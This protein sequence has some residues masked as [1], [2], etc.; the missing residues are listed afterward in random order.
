MNSE[1]PADFGWFFAVKGC[2]ACLE[3]LKPSRGPL[4][5]LGRFVGA[6]VSLSSDIEARNGKRGGGFVEV[7]WIKFFEQLLTEQGDRL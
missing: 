1:E 3:V 7:C 4:V 2:Q 5:V 6:R